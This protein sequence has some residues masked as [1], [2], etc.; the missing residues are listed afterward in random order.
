MDEPSVRVADVWIRSP[1]SR[2]AERSEATVENTRSSTAAKTLRLRAN[3]VSVDRRTVYV[4]AETTSTYRLRYTPSRIGEFDVV[5]NR[6]DAGT[7]TVT[8]PA[9]SDGAATDAPTATGGTNSGTA[10]GTPT[11]TATE[12]PTPWRRR[13]AH[14]Q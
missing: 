14:G 1:T 5:V 13:I 12:R 3:Y 8:A 2:S 9:A 11:P 6:A 4:S 7:L 10:I